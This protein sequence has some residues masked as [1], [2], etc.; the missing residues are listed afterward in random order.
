LKYLKL[1]PWISFYVI[2]NE[3][4][5]LDVVGMVWFLALARMTGLIVIPAKA[6]IQPRLVAE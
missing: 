1:S 6:G 2:L 3:A 4:K 5:N